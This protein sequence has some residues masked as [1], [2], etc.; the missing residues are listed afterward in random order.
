MDQTTPQCSQKIILQNLLITK[1]LMTRSVRGRRHQL[2]YWEK[3]VTGEKKGIRLKIVYVFFQ[4][5]ELNLRL[6]L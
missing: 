2:F 5:T 4:I 6:N 1:K 3:F